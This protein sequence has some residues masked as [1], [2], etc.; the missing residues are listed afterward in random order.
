M[1]PNDDLA[2]WGEPPT[3]RRELEQADRLAEALERGQTGDAGEL[4]QVCRWI[5][6]MM[7]V[8]AEG[9]GLLAQ[10]SA[11]E[12]RLS[13]SR[14][15]GGVYQAVAST[16]ARPCVVRDLRRVPDDPDRVTLRTGDRVRVEAI[17]DRAGY[18]TVYNVGPQGGVNLLYPTS[19]AESARRAAN[20]TVVIG[21]VELTPPA[22]RERVYAVWSEEPLAPRMMLERGATLRDMKRVQQSLSELHDDDWHAVVLELDH[23]SDN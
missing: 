23:A 13:V 4:A 8:V 7:A 10:L 17:C 9:A 11:V 12:L 1:L 16:H 22:G 19:A 3:D 18:L 5:D 20:E 2:K 21:E 15:I 14:R 6:E